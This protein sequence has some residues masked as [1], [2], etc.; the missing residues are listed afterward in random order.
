MHDLTATEPDLGCGEEAWRRAKRIKCALVRDT[1][2]TRVMR[3]CSCIIGIRILLSHLV[4]GLKI[5]ALPCLL[6]RT[7]AFCMKYSVAHDG[8]RANPQ[9]AAVGGWHA[10][11]SEGLPI[12]EARL[13][14]W[15]ALDGGLDNP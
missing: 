2:G 5:G 8:I 7:Y 6:S 12:E 10:D 15:R 14:L 9:S 4:P 1:A 3:T 13:V 11:R